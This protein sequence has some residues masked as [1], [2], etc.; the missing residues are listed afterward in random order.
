LGQG[1]IVVDLEFALFFPSPKRAAPSGKNN[2][3]IR[4]PSMPWKG[5]RSVEKYIKRD[6]CNAPEGLPFQRLR[7]I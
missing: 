2:L 4:E 6:F 5:Y 7:I 1:W 3:K